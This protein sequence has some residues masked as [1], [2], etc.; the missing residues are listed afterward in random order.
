MLKFDGDAFKK[1]A[2]KAV[3]DAMTKRLEAVR[4]PVHGRTARVTPKTGSGSNIEWDIH[5][6]CDELVEQV[7]AAL[8][9]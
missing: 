4:C 9:G 6:C 2:T 5:G 1:K 3:Q 7:K 8:K